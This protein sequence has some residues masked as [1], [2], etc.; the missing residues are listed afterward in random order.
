MERGGGSAHLSLAEDER[1]VIWTL[2]PSFASVADQSVCLGV[3]SLK[4]LK[5][6]KMDMVWFLVGLGGGAKGARRG[7]WSFAGGV[8]AG[9]GQTGTSE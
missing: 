4:L 2:S 3:D 8:P 5:P 7:R 9:P 6:G 1:S